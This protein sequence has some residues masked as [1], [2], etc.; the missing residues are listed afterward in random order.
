MFGLGKKNKN[1]EK[2]DEGN[3]DVTF[4]RKGPTP[5]PTPSA[6][7][8]QQSEEK[9]Q[10]VPPISIKE[11]KALKRAKYDKIA[12]NLKKSFILENIKTGQIVE[13]RGVSAF[14]ACNI[15]GWRKNKVRVLEE[16]AVENEQSETQPET[17]PEA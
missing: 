5:E 7:T 14:H 9:T 16:K 17:Q 3:R 11:M 12:P 10:E 15:I 13:I 8:D 2:N 4:E 6:T 1:D